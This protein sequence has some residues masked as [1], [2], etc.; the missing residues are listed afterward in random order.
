M[1][2]FKSSILEVLL[3]IICVCTLMLYKIPDTICTWVLNSLA[4]F[5]LGFAIIK[6]ALKSLIH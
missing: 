4:C 5:M 1:N 2:T 6:I 3:I